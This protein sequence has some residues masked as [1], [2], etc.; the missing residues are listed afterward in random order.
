MPLYRH[1]YLE[2]EAVI[3]YSHALDELD[4]GNIPEWTN[5]AAPDIAK[6]YWR[7]KVKS[8]IL[9]LKFWDGAVSDS[10]L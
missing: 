5:M 9:L 3:T 2:E 8:E 1:R 7:L 4:A 10:H 6:V